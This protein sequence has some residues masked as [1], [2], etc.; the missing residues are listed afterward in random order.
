[1]PHTYTLELPALYGS[2]PLG[3]LAALGT[4]HLTTHLLDQPPRLSWSGPDAPALLH[5]HIP[6]TH[7][8][9]AELLATQLPKN[10][11]DDPLAVAPG[12]LNQPRTPGGPN[13]PLKM[14]ID[15]A[16]HKLRTYAQAERD[17]NDNRAHWFSAL[18]N[19]LATKA[20]DTGAPFTRT[21]PYFGHTSRMTLPN[22][23][24]TAAQFCK[25]D[26][27]QLP[28]A[29]T[30]WQRV[31]EY[32]GA[33]LD[34]HST[35]DAH[36]V[37][38][39]KPTQQGVPGATWLALHG[40]LAFRLIGNTNDP[41]ATSWNTPKKAFTWPTWHPPLT[42]TSLTTLLEHPLLYASRPDPK[43]LRNLGITAL[44]TAPRTRLPKGD[45]PLQPGRRHPL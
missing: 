10:P 32:A 12:I 16:L 13:E 5:T 4:L 35:G 7:T 2:S 30:R 42:T 45:G 38:H 34:H 22:N 36:M 3:F 44:Y 17:H 37:S 8:T 15:E 20:S 43:R 26:P 19:T 14:P 24:A 6:Y 25:D 23:W 18:V 11:A 33:N 41:H 28:A 21:T 1:M 40:F 29:L 31:E 39:S 9:L 27:A